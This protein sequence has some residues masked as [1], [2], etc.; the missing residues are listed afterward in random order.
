MDHHRDKECPSD[1]SLPSVIV[2]RPK[3]IRRKKKSIFPIQLSEQDEKDQGRTCVSVIL[4]TSETVPERVMRV[5]ELSA[6]H[7]VRYQCKSSQQGGARLD[8]C[9]KSA[10]E[11][12]QFFRRVND[13]ERRRS[14]SVILTT[15][16]GLG[17]T[18]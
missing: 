12:R 18:S 6:K 15:E 2:C 13:M 5:E 7:D 17:E 11:A 1:P 9:F 10:T 14:I 4:K 8:F 16:A 3:L